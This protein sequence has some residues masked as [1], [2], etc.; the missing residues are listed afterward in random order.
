M[1]AASE[2][3]IGGAYMAAVSEA[4]PALPEIA[5][6]EEET[7]LAEEPAIAPPGTP[8]TCMWYPVQDLPVCTSLPG[9]AIFV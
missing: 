2:T 9:C 4:A 1:V 3:Q 7:E 5:E 8:T 6:T